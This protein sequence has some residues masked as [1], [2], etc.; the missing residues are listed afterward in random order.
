MKGF[1]YCENKQNVTQRHELSTYCWKIGAN[2]LV[3]LRVATNCQFMKHPISEKHNKQRYACI[4]LF[5]IHCFHLCMV[6]IALCILSCDFIIF[7]LLCLSASNSYCPLS[8]FLINILKKIS[9]FIILTEQSVHACPV[10]WPLV[11]HYSCISEDCVVACHLLHVA[12][13]FGNNFHDR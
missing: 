6:S 5:C 1:K 11:S 13:H 9:H 2:R 4:W 7:G 3:G 12:C 10:Y 8:K